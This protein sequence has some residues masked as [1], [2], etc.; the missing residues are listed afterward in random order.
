[1]KTIET[2][3][4][5]A[6]A[7]WNAIR[8]PRKTADATALAEREGYGGYA[9]P[10]DLD[11]KLSAVRAK[12]NIF[13]QLSTV[14]TSSGTANITVPVPS[15]EAHYL[16]EGETCPTDAAAFNTTALDYKKVGKLSIMPGEWFQD[17]HFDLQGCLAARFGRAFGQTEEQGIIGGDGSLS[18][19]GLLD[20]THGAEVGIT[21]ENITFDTLSSL[22]FTLEKEYRSNGAWV[23][24]DATAFALRGLKDSAGAYLWN[25]TND[26]LF[27]KPVFI[28]R[29][30]PDVGEGS[31]PVFFGDFSYLWLVERGDVVF[32]TLTELYMPNNCVGVYSCERFDVKLTCR[33]AIKALQ[34]TAE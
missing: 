7:F 14:M 16:S 2:S 24:N 10:T 11:A 29:F 33:D 31:K 3:A 20:D 6:A 25:N 4:K 13:R 22:Y 28:S 32:R 8:S 5:Y 15:D 21:V 18:P 17:I 9:A 23:M 12:H 1:M 27:G 34:M 19:L 30:M 26:T